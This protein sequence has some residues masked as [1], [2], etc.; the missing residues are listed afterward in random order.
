[1]IVEAHECLCILLTFQRINKV[2]LHCVDGKL[3][4]AHE[5]EL[6]VVKGSESLSNWFIM[7]F[8]AGAELRGS[9]EFWRL[10]GLRFDSCEAYG[11]R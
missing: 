11:L 7:L 2:L 3:L 1:M 10:T 9:D 6:V 4:L 5:I 8:E